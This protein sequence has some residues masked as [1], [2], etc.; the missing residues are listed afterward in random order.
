MW[1]FANKV[2]PCM[3]STLSGGRGNRDRPRERFTIFSVLP[4]MDRKQKQAEKVQYAHTAI[5]IL[6]FFP[7]TL[8]FH[9]SVIPPSLFLTFLLQTLI[10]LFLPGPTKS[11]EHFLQGL[12]TTQGL[13]HLA[14][15]A[16]SFFFSVLNSWEAEG[17]QLFSHCLGNQRACSHWLCILSALRMQSPESCRRVSDSEIQ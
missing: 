11:I 12:S 7:A 2:T 14:D 6:H 8:S 13:C 5:N 9:A 16:L 1:Q 10:P 17:G 4:A 15:L 3:G